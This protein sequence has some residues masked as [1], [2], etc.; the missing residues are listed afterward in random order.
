MRYFRSLKNSLQ[1]QRSEKPNSETEI[2]SASHGK[3]LQTG[4]LLPCHNGLQTQ[5]L[6]SAKEKKHVVQVYKS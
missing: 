4:C 2:I 5:Q 6:S 3:A 1:Y